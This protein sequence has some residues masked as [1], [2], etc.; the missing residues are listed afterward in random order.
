MEN[1][2]KKFNAKRPVKCICGYDKVLTLAG[3]YSHRLT[4]KHHNN[5]MIMIRN[6]YVKNDIFEKDYIFQDL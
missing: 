3:W 5:K 4:R 1:E 2:K 6:G